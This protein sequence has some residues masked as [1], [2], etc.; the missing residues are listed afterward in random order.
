MELIDLDE[1]YRTSATLYKK[2]LG[3]VSDQPASRIGPWAENYQM[4]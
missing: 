3:G 1:I 4:C 2:F